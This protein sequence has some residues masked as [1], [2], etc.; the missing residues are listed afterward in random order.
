MGCGLFGEHVKSD[1]ESGCR[2]LAFLK[3]IIHRSKKATGVFRAATEC[4]C[5]PT[6][7]S[8]SPFATEGASFR[9]PAIFLRMAADYAYRKGFSLFS[10]VF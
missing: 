10:Y 1:G 7:G 4:G 3:T 6:K 8:E 2:E 5:G 9:T